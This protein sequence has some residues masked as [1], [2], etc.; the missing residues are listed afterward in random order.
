VRDDELNKKPSK[1]TLAGF[2]EVGTG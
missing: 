1:V 2:A